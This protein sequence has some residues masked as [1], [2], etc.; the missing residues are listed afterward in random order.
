[1][2]CLSSPLL[3]SFFVSSVPV[4]LRVIL[5]PCLSIRFPVSV[6]VSVPLLGIF[7]PVRVVSSRAVPRAVLLSVTFC[8]SG[9]AVCRGFASLG[10]ELKDVPHSRHG[11]A[12]SECISELFW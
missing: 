10:S 9:S 4:S 7:V 6:S 2:S 5:F 1:M 3:S 8:D 12:V 11:M